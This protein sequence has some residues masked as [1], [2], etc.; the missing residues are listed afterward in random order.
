MK[1]KPVQAIAMPNTAAHSLR[2]LLVGSSILVAALIWGTVA[3]Q[4]K[5]QNHMASRL[6]AR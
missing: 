1:S 5:L 3:R 6:S 2:T 4:R